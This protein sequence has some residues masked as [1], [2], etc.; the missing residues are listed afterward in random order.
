MK[1]I[2]S[3]AIAAAVCMGAVSCG[4]KKQNKQK[5][6]IAVSAPLYSY[7]SANI[8][9]ADDFDRIL[10][11]DMDDRSG[12]ILIF[13]QTGSGEWNGLVTDKAFSES[14]TFSFSPDENEIVLGAGFAGT[15]KKAVLSYKEGSAVIHIISADGTEEKSL[16]CGIALNISPDENTMGEIYPCGEGFVVRIRETAF[17]IDS[18]GDAEEINTKGADIYGVFSNGDNSVTMLLNNGG[19]IGTASVNGTDID[20]LHKCEN[21]GS[22]PIAMCCGTD[23]FSCIAAFTDGIYGLEGEKWIRLSDFTDTPF[24]GMNVLRII[25][26]AENEF[27]VLVRTESGTAVY[28]LT[29]RDISELKS[30]K[31][32]RVAVY[33]SDP[34]TEELVRN[35]NKANEN[36]AYR[37]EL[38]VYSGDGNASEGLTALKTDIISGNAPDVIANQINGINLN[39]YYMDLYEFID[40]DSQLSRESFIPNILEGMSVDGKLPS[41]CAYPVL[42][43]VISKSSYSSVTQNW[44]YTD[45]AAACKAMPDDMKLCPNVDIETMR[46]NFISLMNIGNFADY[47]HGTCCFD[48]PEFIEMLK[49]FKEKHFGMTDN[50][51]DIYMEESGGAVYFGGAEPS[52]IRSDRILF[53]RLDMQSF[54]SVWLITDCYGGEDVF[55]GFPSTDG[56]GSYFRA[57]AFDELSIPKTADNPDG[58][59]DFI[60]YCLSDEV[61]MTNGGRLKIP[62]IKEQFEKT[63]ES[64]LKNDPKNIDMVR[65]SDDEN[66]WPTAVTADPETGETII[67]EPLTE[68]ELE[69]Y[70][71]FFYEAAKNY[72]R[73]DNTLELEIVSEELEEYFNSDKS[74]EET[75]EMIQNRASVYLSETYG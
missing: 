4:N 70:K 42:S 46:A 11:V 71:S 64:C 5:D 57:E 65:L 47:A 29:E 48:S 21:I 67:I 74:A 23:R 16:D 59:W 68:K 73:Q 63:A 9:I 54:R 36:G 31:T 25:M 7:N 39:D 33:L 18:D 53:Q 34:Q 56:K 15:G 20:N 61:Y 3:I 13:G 32:F 6:S 2:I 14:E 69:H 66:E 1:K 43:T 35:Y 58:A 37:A 19:T 27:A 55:T 38:V 12:Q 17:F 22:S 50:E 30:K 49:L 52:D 75:A 8:E 62:I 72:V 10:S 26:T 41:L 51:A 28:L 40:S 24:R 44:N 60:R 45:F